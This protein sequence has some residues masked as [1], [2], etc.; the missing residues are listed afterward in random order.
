MC[1][2]HIKGNGNTKKK[3]LT[4]TRFCYCNLST[5]QH[6]INRLVNIIIPLPSFSDSNKLFTFKI[7]DR[8]FFPVSA[9]L[10][11]AACLVIFPLDAYLQLQRHSS[12]TMHLTESFMKMYDCVLLPALKLL[13]LLI[14]IVN[15]TIMW[16]V[17]VNSLWSITGKDHSTLVSST[18]TWCTLKVTFSLSKVNQQTASFQLPWTDH[19]YPPK[20]QKIFKRG[21]LVPFKE[22]GHPI[23]S[24]PL[25]F[26]Q[27]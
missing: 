18:A 19:K 21:R 12:Q 25:H 26:R 15:M 4:E 24:G 13:T 7:T 27:H 11:S 23:Q 20:K 5:A 22:V 3:W 14:Q 9:A 16:K 10:G 17:S 1:S 8:L 6:S 2:I